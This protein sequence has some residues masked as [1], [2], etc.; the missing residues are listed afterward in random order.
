MENNRSVPGICSHRLSVTDY[1]RNFGEALMPLTRNQGGHTGD[2][3][4]QYNQAA[5]L[6]CSLH[7]THQRSHF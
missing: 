3:S 6:R 1:A 5:A 4:I 7:G 2:E